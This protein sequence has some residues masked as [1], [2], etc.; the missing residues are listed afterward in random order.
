MYYHDNIFKLFFSA[1]FTVNKYYL[2]NYSVYVGKFFLFELSV[3]IW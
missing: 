3:L 2:I 1:S